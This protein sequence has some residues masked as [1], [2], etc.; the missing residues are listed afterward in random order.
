MA[1]FQIN[2]SIYSK[3]N[4]STITVATV[5]VVLAVGKLK[6]LGVIPR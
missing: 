4:G 2:C 3:F 5:P 1:M 6:A